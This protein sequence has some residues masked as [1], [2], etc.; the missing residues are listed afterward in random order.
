M[1][2]KAGHLLSYCSVSASGSTN[3]DNLQL[4]NISNLTTD[5]L[6]PIII[7]LLI[8]RGLSVVSRS[9]EVSIKQE[10]KNQFFIP[11][12]NIIHE[13]AGMLAHVINII[14]L[15]LIPMVIIHVNGA[16]F[17]LCKFG[18][19]E[20]NFFAIQTISNLFSMQHPQ[21]VQVRC[22]SIIRYYS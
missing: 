13:G 15:V 19:F 17:S 4:N 22:A 2:A 7:C 6:V 20:I 21:S 10:E 5:S 14:V 18:F 3:G 8:E 1:Q 9:T 11:L 12:Q 16:S